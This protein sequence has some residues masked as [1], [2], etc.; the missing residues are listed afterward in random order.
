MINRN[1]GNNQAYYILDR[2]REKH[3][4][5]EKYRGEKCCYLYAVIEHFHYLNAGTGSSAKKTT[6]YQKIN[7]PRLSLFYI[8][9]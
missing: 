6:L 7:L 8:L 1:V 5:K 2:F 9:L 3:L 4:K